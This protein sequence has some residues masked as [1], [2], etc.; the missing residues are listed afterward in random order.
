M[1]VDRVGAGL[2]DYPPIGAPWRRDPE[3]SR[4]NTV[5]LQPADTDTTQLP[6][7]ALLSKILLALT[8]EV[9]R[10]SEV[11]LSLSANVLRVLDDRGV[12]VRDLPALTGV[13]EMGIVNSLSLLQQSGHATV[14]TAPVGGR[15]KIAAL[16]PEGA[17][18]QG[19]YRRRSE[20]IEQTW[21]KHFGREPIGA[22]RTSL[23]AALG[24]AEPEEAPLLR[25]LQPYPDGWRAQVARPK[26]LPHFPM[27]SHRGGFPDGA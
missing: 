19:V 18:A 23:E 12:R 3:P 26:V 6:I 2:L 14:G 10:D 9:E 20:D 15:T 11:G 21:T 16:T 17:E 22:L 24:G 5:P 1:I 27:I 13:A 25:G 8:I 7:W 4:H